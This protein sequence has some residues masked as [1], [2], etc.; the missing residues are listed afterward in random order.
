MKKA[1]TG[2]S[3]RWCPL[4]FL[5]TTTFI[6]T[7]PSQ[8]LSSLGRNLHTQVTKWADFVS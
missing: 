4:A 5:K 2:S 8:K 3:F 7:D 6:A 1:F